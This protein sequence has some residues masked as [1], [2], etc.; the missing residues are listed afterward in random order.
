M[1]KLLLALMITMLSFSNIVS[2]S[3][4]TITNKENT[5]IKALNTEM[6]A[7]DYLFTEHNIKQIHIPTG[8]P[9]DTTGFRRISDYY[10]PRKRHPILKC[11]RMHHG[12]DFAG[13]KGTTIYPAAKGTVK[14]IR[15]S[16]SYGRLII[17]DHGNDIT[18][19][20]AHLHKIT[21]NKGDTVRAG[22]KIGELGSTGWS[23][24]PHLHYEIRVKDRA[25]NPLELLSIEQDEQELLQTMSNQTTL[26]Q[27]KKI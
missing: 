21:V 25:I 26:K 6:N 19:M 27:W 15:R 2:D 5:I 4:P 20:Y 1:K 24:G 14:E 11:R 12:I 8:I 16:I 23:T 3:Y 22:E 7:N 17:I 10:G 9:L 18:T 13:T